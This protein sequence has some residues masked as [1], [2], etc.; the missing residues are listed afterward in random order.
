MSI[1]AILI[2]IAF[3]IIYN[4]IYGDGTIYIFSK[5]YLYLLFQEEADTRIILHCCHI[6]THCTDSSAII[7]RSPDTDVFLLLMK[8]SQNIRIP[9]IMDTGVADKRRLIDIRSAVQSIG[10]DLCNALLSLHAFTG[11]DTISSFVRKGKVGPLRVLQKNPQYIPVFKGLGTSPTVTP[12]Q[13][14]DL[15]A[16]TCLLYGARSGI[17]DINKLRYTMFMTRFTPKNQLLSSES[18]IDLSLLPPC[19]SSLRMHVVRANYQALIW[20]QANW[21]YPELPKPYNGHGWVL[22][23][24]KLGYQWTEEDEMLPEELVDLVL[25]QDDDEEE[26]DDDYYNIQEGLFEDDEE[27]DDD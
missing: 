3:I 5:Q 10:N 9:L 15:E 23:G 20:N 12:G 22:Q 8:F 27:E 13:F 25:E 1:L 11:C 7:V 19:R 4:T 26:E 24:D 21:A 2:H 6:A 14:D 18:G 16:F 17:K